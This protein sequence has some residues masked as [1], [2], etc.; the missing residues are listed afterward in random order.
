TTDDLTDRQ[1]V[2]MTYR[3][4]FA[5]FSADPAIGTERS[6]TI[7]ATKRIDNT[8]FIK[9]AFELPFENA[10]EAFRMQNGSFQFDIPY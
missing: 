3:R 8:I 10:S 9:G 1:R 7:S 2:L 5:I 6:M 4:T